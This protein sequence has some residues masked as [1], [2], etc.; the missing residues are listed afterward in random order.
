MLGTPITFSVDGRQY[1]A[2]L[3]GPLNGSV[4][5]FGAVSA[6]FGWNAREHP[7]RLLAFA[8]DGRASLP[9]TPPPRHV[10]PLAAP[11]FVVDAAA[12][13]VGANQYSRCM[14]CHGPGAVAGG[15]APDLRASAVVLSSEAFATIVRGG[16]LESRGM[17][18]FAELSDRELDGLR[19]YIRSQAEHSTAK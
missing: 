10:E 5:G 2:M 14:L 17:P 12:V 6:Q 4:G 13:Q 9:S 15:T 7:R 1:L 3:A 18:K 16:S 8:L 19:H 11:G